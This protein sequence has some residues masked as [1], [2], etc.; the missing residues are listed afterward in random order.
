MFGRN[1]DSP[2]A[3]VAPQSPV[4][5]FDMAIEAVRIATR[6]M[7]PVFYLSDGY[8]ANGSEPW[9]I[10]AV[11]DLKPIEIAHPT[12]PN[13]EGTNL[14]HESGDTDAGGGVGKFLPYKRDELL[15]RP[16]AIPGTAGLEHRIGGI[17]KQDVTGNINYEPANH[18]HMTHTRWK[19]IENIAE[20][21]PELAV[22]GDAAAELL[23]IGWGGTFG[24]ITTA[25]ERARRKGQKVAQAHLRYLNPMPKNTE[26]VLKRFPKILVPELNTGQLCW[27]LRAK[28]LVPAEGL[29]KVQGKPFLVSELEA[30]IEKALGLGP[31]L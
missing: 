14:A 15:S 23:V 18:E 19:K 16:W 1:G 25:V 5:C 10:P 30:A 27:L 22:T 28:Y 11:A 3:I 7:C 13:S 9:K 21:I 20:T 24:S 2:V 17:E 4:D 12:G 6:F 31:V 29:N 26:A 8:I